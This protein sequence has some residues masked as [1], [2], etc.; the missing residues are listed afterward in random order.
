MIRR[1]KQVEWTR[2]L[3]PED[4][5]YL[6]E[7]I[8]QDRWYP[9]AAFERLGNAILREIAH[10]DL[11]LVRMWG[12][13]QVDEQRQTYTSLIAEG[14]PV[15][16]L[17]RFRVLRATFFDFEALTVPLIHEDEAPMII[18]YHMGKSAEEAASYQT[19][20]FFERLLELSGATTVSAKF[21]SRSWAGDE[22]TRLELQWLMGIGPRRPS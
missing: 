3:A 22:E 2:V 14:D 1:Q 19:M 9:M 11:V 4:R 8:R 10:G 16:T 15:E 21:L 12:R 7:R 5:R 20:G 6:S 17:F 13:Y 18:R